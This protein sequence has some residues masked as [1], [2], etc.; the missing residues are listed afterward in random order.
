MNNFIHENGYNSNAWWSFSSRVDHNFNEKS[1]L[2]GRYGFTD[3]TLNENGYDFA[4]GASAGNSKG[5]SKVAALDYTHVFDASTV[6][7]VRYGYTR[8]YFGIL[9]MTNGFDMSTLGLPKSLADS[10]VFKQFP[11][12]VFGSNSYSTTNIANEYFDHAGVHSV[13]FNFSRTQGRHLLRAGLDFRNTLTTAINHTGESGVFNFTGGYMNGPLDNSATPAIM[14]G[15]MGGFLLG[16][17]S[18]AYVN[19][20]ASSAGVVRTTGVFVQDDWKVSDRLTLNIGLRYEYESA[21][22]ERFDRGVRGFDYNVASPV[23]AAAKAAY[24]QNPIPELPVSQYSAKGGLTFLGV[25]GQPRTLY[26]APKRN[27]MPRFGFAYSLT[28][29]TVLRGGYGIFFNQL[30]LTV[31]NFNQTGFSQATNFVPT[32]DNGVTFI[33]TLSNPFPG[34]LLPPV[35]A[36]D[37]IA[38]NLGRD[39]SFQNTKL[40]TP[41]M[42]SWSLGIQRALPAG[43][44]ADI[45]YV[46]SRGNCS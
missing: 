40:R 32:L 9:S 24:A 8:S 41:Y 29:V 28:P 27:F 23:E 6:A 43:F 5:V 38:T 22:V 11:Q 18:N 31:R 16:L 3:R 35:G 42:Q 15:S 12:F 37:G 21:P 33:S 4:K 14:A 13:A 10:V 44:L 1:R 46:G 20:N 34:G 7:D 30:G 36:G 45:S 2:F 39:I 17:P 25:N 26:E 19:L